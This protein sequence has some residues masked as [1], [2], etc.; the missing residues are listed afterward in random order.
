MYVPKSIN[1]LPRNHKI[2][3]VVG[4]SEG[5]SDDEIGCFGTWR[6]ACPESQQSKPTL[7]RCRVLQDAF[8]IDLER[9]PVGFQSTK[10]RSAISHYAH[11]PQVQPG[12]GTVMFI[13]VLKPVEIQQSTL[14]YSVLYS[15]SKPQVGLAQNS[16]YLRVQ[17]ISGIT[18][19]LLFFVAIWFNCNA[20]QRR[21]AQH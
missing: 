5:S 7:V 16:N 18:N 8:L 12:Y 19:Y 2:L 15:Y 9:M 4:N 13:G 14:L 3:Q 21:R 11:D 10:Y 6:G 1:L 20:P 17:V